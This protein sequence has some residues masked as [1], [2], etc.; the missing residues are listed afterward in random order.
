MVCEFSQ[1]V[2]NQKFTKDMIAYLQVQYEKNPDLGSR[3][4]DIADLFMSTKQTI[5]TTWANMR[6][7]D[8]NPMYDTYVK[9][10]ADQVKILENAFKEDKSFSPK[11]IAVVLGLDPNNPK[12]IK[13]IKNWKQRKVQKAKKENEGE[14]QPGS[15]KDK[16]K[17]GT[18]KKT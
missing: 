14:A 16:P 4:Q 6:K 9:F 15:S 1:R 7:K 8:N 11:S 5:Q 10:N 2:K 17:P 18:S 13:K 12:H 3:A